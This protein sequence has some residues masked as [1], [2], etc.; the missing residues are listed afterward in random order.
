MGLS[1]AAVLFL[2]SLSV[3]GVEL[4][5]P[6]RFAA[7]LTLVPAN[8]AFFGNRIFAGVIEMKTFRWALVPCDRCPSKKRDTDR[9]V[10][11]QGK[12]R[13]RLG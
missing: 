13:Q 11:G 12:V 1:A 7:F 5:P 10:Q 2:N 9:D 4:C 3:C 6:K 8:V